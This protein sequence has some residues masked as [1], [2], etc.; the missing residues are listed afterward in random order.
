MICSKVLL[1]LLVVA[2]A[3]LASQPLR[4]AGSSNVLEGVWFR[5]EFAHSQIPPNDDCRMLDDDG[6]QVV[7]GIVHH[8]KITNSNETKCRH[9]RVGNCF[10]KN[11]TGLSAERTEIGPIE[12][13]K[14]TALVTWLGCTQKYSL[15]NFGSF[16]E[17]VPDQEQCWW[18]P[19]KRYFISFYQQPLQLV[20]E[21]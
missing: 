14:N 13:F 5:C 11:Q 4:A 9:D 19:D 21:E 3:I 18:T 10:L 6:F 17:I 2:V 1:K 12:F 16:I 8:V 20:D 15:S 7:D